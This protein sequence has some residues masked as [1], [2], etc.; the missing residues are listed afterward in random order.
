M[1]EYERKSWGFRCYFKSMASPCELL[2][3]TTEKV[4]AKKLARTAFNECKRIEKK[5]SRYQKNNLCFRMNHSAGN[6]VSIDQET[7]QILQYAEQLFQLSHGRFD[8]T[9]GILR[10]IWHFDLTECL[11]DK[12][13]IENLLPCIGFEKINYNSQEFKLPENMEID[14]GGIGK[15]Y[16][17]DRIY[18]LVLGATKNNPVDFLINLG[19]DIIA[20]AVSEKSPAWQVG[21][22]SITDQNHVDKLISLKQGALATS[23]TTKRYTLANGEVFGHILNPKSGYPV[24]N[25]PQ[26]ITVLNDNCT[27]AGSL[28]TLAMLQGE[29]AEHFLESEQVRH[30]ILR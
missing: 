17:A 25:A 11:P 7:F 23:G 8:I 12:S 21:I 30:W 22:E 16:C 10:K 9:S 28:A 24:K 5:Y 20:H 13:A 14:F 1:I 15:E 18:Q 29:N 2:V 4:R 6:A 3:R 19:G 26:S 27:A